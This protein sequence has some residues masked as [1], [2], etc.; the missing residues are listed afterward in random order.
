MFRVSIYVA[1]AAAIALAGCGGSSDEQAAE[2]AVERAIEKETGGRAKA[3]I[4]DEG[5]EITADGMSIATHADGGVDLPDD[6]PK[7]VYVLQG[8][9]VMAT[10]RDGT[11]FVLTLQ[12]DQSLDQV[13]SAY[14]SK[15]AAEGWDLKTEMRMGLGD[16]LAFEKNG[17]SAGVSLQTNEGKTIVSLSASSK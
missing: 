12:S 15:M 1:I 9:S 6:F 5:I 14:K 10:M 11:D 3:D 16:M 2:I 17:R 13:R 7:D 4:S 8:A